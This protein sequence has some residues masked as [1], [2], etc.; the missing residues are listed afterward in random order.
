MVQKSYV[1][2]YVD[3][4]TFILYNQVYGGRE[5]NLWYPP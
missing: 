3:I 1:F 2:F 5:E 4:G